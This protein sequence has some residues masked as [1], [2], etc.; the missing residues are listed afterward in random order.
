MHHTYN[1]EDQEFRS[2]FPF[3]HTLAHAIESSIRKLSKFIPQSNFMVH[4]SLSRRY[5]SKSL[6]LLTIWFSLIELSMKL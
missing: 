3:F 2:C 5:D 4:A 6:A 1:Q